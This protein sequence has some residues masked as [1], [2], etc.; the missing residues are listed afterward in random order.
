MPRSH[1][2]QTC[3]N[4]ALAPYIW[5][6]HMLIPNQGEMFDHV[7]PW[8]QN[9][10]T[11][12]L[13]KKLKSSKTTVARASTPQF[14]LFWHVNNVMEIHAYVHC[15]AEQ[16]GTSIFYSRTWFRFCFIPIR[17]GRQSWGGWGGHI[18]PPTFWTGGDTYIVIP[19]T[20]CFEK[21]KLKCLNNNLFQYFSLWY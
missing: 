14:F 15:M 18:P 2:L 6:I 17:Q 3:A 12:R 8:L 19:P 4:C 11:C 16:I 13:W 5:I 20:F 10:C 7:P 21:F 9:P 1:N